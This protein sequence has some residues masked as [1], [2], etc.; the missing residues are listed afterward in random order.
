MR[1]ICSFFRLT[2]SEKYI[3]IE[4]LILLWLIRLML[5]VFPFSLSQKIIKEITISKDEKQSDKFSV[6]KI[7]WAVELMS[8]YTL[9]ATCLTQALATQILL[10]K[11]NYSSR[12][13]IGVSKN[14]QEFEAHAWV[15][16]HDLIVLGNSETHYTPIMDI[17]NNNTN[18]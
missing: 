5:W 1:I 8:N 3:L 18:N 9:N 4:A 13:L 7:I 6:K 14:K 16:S 2:R 11:Y 12:V 10:T 15:E 17:D